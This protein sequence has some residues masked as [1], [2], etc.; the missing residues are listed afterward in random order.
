M[1]EKT[2]RTEGDGVKI[3]VNGVIDNDPSDMTN[4]IQFIIFDP[5]PPCPTKDYLHI[6]TTDTLTNKPYE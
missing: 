5:D 1:K 6:T 2:Q 3:V 4:L